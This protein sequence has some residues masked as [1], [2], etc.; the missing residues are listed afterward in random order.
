M[1]KC[2]LLWV[3]CLVF[4][5]PTILGSYSLPAI[6]MAIIDCDMKEFAEAREA[7]LWESPVVNWDERLKTKEDVLDLI[8]KISNE[9]GINP[10]FVMAVVA[11]ESNFN[12]RAISRVGAVG[13]MQ[14][15]PKT[16]WWLDTSL[17]VYN[18]EDNLRLGIRYFKMMRTKF[19]G[20]TKLALAAYNAGPHRVQQAGWKIPNLTETQLYVPRVM[21]FYNK[22][23]RIVNYA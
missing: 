8:I 18:P 23:R 20:Y 21:A 3:V 19:K 9:E 7:E 5:I 16:A 2:I 10:V 14:V 22:F 15:M 11:A 6:D 1:K 13:L 17:D 4:S 12:H